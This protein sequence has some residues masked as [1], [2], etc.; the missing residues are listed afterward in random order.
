MDDRFALARKDPRYA[1]ALN[2]PVRGPSI[3]GP[4][5]GTA[6]LGGMG[7]V[8]YAI[9]WWFGV[10]AWAMAAFMLVMTVR[11]IAMPVRRQLLIVDGVQTDLVGGGR[12]QRA[13][14]S[15]RFRDE[16]GA[17]ASYVAD[18]G[19]SIQEPGTIGVAAT[20]GGTLLGFDS[21]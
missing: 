6:L 13:V 19:L 8:F 14:H 12:R 18:G 17:F 9:E 11:Y 16:Q 3:A 21:L 20:R 1:E 2:T 5:A 4:L 15:V 10:M 7:V